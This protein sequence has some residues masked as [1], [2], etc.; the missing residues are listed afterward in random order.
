MAYGIQRSVL[1][2]KKIQISR[3]WTSNVIGFACPCFV[4]VPVS[5]WR[6]HEKEQTIGEHFRCNLTR[7]STLA[8]TH[9]NP[10]TRPLRRVL[11][12]IK[13]LRCLQEAFRALQ[14]STGA[15]QSFV[16]PLLRLPLRSSCRL[17]S[18]SVLQLFSIASEQHSPCV[19]QLFGQHSPLSTTAI[20]LFDIY[21]F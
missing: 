15:L 10:A 17:R 8:S 14:S 11:A 5:A 7:I 16:S 21:T 6:Q 3:S 19:L 18:T 1:S 12:A 20:V 4:A 13:P 9:C 2:F